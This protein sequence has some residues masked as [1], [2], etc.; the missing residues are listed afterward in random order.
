MRGISDFI[1]INPKS[2]WSIKVTAPESLQ[3]LGTDVTNTENV[4]KIFFINNDPEVAPIEIG[5]IEANVN[6]NQTNNVAAMNLLRNIMWD[7]Q[8]GQVRDFLNWQV[9]KADAQNL[10]NPDAGRSAQA[11][12]N[13]AAIVDDGILT[14]AGSSIVYDV[15]GVKLSAP[16]TSDDSGHTRIVY[17]Q[18]TTSNASNA[19]PA[20]PQNSTPQGDGAII[21]GDGQPVD[22]NSGANLGTSNN[23][24]LP[25]TPPRRNA[26]LER[27]EAV[28]RRIIEE[29]DTSGRL[30]L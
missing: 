8:T 6:S 29:S 11:K 18:D 21:A 3:I 10:K 15:D 24:P 7:S 16:I 17:P 19:Q 14:I 25:S 13:Y 26:N 23:G 2:G 28:T 22:P 27:A 30:T 9:P 12:R 1:Y 4:Y 20:A 5:T